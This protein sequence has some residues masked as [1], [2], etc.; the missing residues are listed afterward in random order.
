M[1]FLGLF[2]IPPFSVEYEEGLMPFYV[3]LL[4]EETGQF[5]GRRNCND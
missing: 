5:S 3:E 2:F 4:M 1:M